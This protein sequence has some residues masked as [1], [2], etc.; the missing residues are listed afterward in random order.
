M[1]QEIN[2]YGI[3]AVLLVLLY[4]SGCKEGSTAPEIEIET[5]TTFP[6]EIQGFWRLGFFGEDEGGFYFTEDKIFFWGYNTS[7]FH[8]EDFDQDS[9][10]VNQEWAVLIQY[11]GDVY[12]LRITD[13]TEDN[14][15]EELV[16]TMLAGPESLTMYETAIPD[17][18]LV[19]SNSPR[20]LE[21]MDPVCEY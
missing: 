9:C 7:T 21:D 5:G 4:V 15:N 3:L 8:L 20:V 16:L 12:T 11:E 19:M 10:F 17:Q 2:F 1:K 13:P 6:G 14:Y 18:R